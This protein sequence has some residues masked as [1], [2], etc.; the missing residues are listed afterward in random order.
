MTRNRSAVNAINPY[1]RTSQNVFWSDLPNLQAFV[2]PPVI[3]NDTESTRSEFDLSSRICAFDFGSWDWTAS[4]IFVMPSHNSHGSETFPPIPP[5][6]IISERIWPT[7][8]VRQSFS[9]SSVGKRTARTPWTNSCLYAASFAIWSCVLWPPSGM[10][11]SAGN[12]HS[13]WY[14]C[15][16]S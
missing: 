16:G 8:V 1:W 4:A 13:E 5:P 12:G 2:L 6:S 10:G 11:D 3:F 9:K 15:R 14:I 7:S